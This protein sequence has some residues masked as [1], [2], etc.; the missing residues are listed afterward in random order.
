MS[1]K[2]HQ[3][4]IRLTKSQKGFVIEEAERLG[5][6]MSELIRRIVD[7]YRFPGRIIVPLDGPE[8]DW[9]L[10]LSKAI[11]DTPGMAVRLALIMHRQVMQA[12]LGMILRPPE[13]VMEELI[14]SRK[15]MSEEKVPL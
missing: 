6:S 9:I 5:I 15:R 3:T 12:P 10:D 13:K 8:L 1:S 7:D 11:K 4:M 2:D 14:A